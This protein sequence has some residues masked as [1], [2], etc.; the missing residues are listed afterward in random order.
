M[1]FFLSIIRHTRCALVT[2]VQTCALPISMLAVAIYLISPVIPSVVHMSL[3]AVLLII[4]AMYLNVLD[5][6]PDSSPGFV[7]FCKG[8]GVLAPI[9]GLPL[10]IGVLSGL[11]D[12]LT[13]L[14]GVCGHIFVAAK[15]IRFE[16]T[17]Y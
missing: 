3:W 7:R 17:T 12:V 9:L 16:Q 13:H 11:R 5:P 15:H 8:V 14:I 10:L 4:S 2:G 6:L 1:F